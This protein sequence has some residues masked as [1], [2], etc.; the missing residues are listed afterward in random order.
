M[1]WDIMQ[2]ENAACSA[3]ENGKAC[4]EVA[5]ELEDYR[6]ALNICSDCLV[7][8]SQQQNGTLSRE[9]IDEILQKKG[10]CILQKKCSTCK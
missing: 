5:G 6:S 10:V 4:W 8:L 2:C 9:E 7:Y 1:C 3:R